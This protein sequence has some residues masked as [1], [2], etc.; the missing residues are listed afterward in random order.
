MIIDKVIGIITFV[1]SLS[2][3]SE[4]VVE[5]VKN[6]P[7]V[8]E[9]VS[10]KSDK[11]LKEPIRRILIYLFAGVVAFVLA[12]L[13]SPLI[14][15]EVLQNRSDPRV[16]LAFA[17][18]ASAGSSFWNSLSGALE[19]LKKSLNAKNE[20]EQGDSTRAAGAEA[21]RPV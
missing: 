6:L 9:L 8:F 4:R 20:P 19:Q 15:A 17:V 10:E 3:A 16:W 1:T 11:K 12:A 2:V 21:L 7:G 18:L 13:S 14:P 5:L